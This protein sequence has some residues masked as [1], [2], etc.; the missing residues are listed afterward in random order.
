MY[1]ECKYSNRRISYH[2]FFI[3]MCDGPLF[4]RQKKM[5]AINGEIFGIKE[6]KRKAKKVKKKSNHFFC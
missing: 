2:T 6:R 4:W 3:F 5:R 1:V